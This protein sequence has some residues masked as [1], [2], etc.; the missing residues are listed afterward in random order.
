MHRFTD[1]T[2]RFVETLPLAYREKYH[3][4]TIEAHARLALRRE[5]PVEVGVFERQGDLTGVCIVADDRAGL[6]ALISE[7]LVLCDIDVVNAEAFT[8]QV[9]SSQLPAGQVLG[10]QPPGGAANN[11]L[12]AKDDTRPSSSRLPIAHLEGR[13]RYE[14]VDLFWLRKLERERSQ[15]LESQDLERLRTTLES[16]LDRTL[17]AGTAMPA[18]GQVTKS[19]SRVRFIDDEEGS[20]S[21][22]EIET[23]DRSGLLLSVSRA[24]FGQNV[25]VVRCEVRT[26]A[27]RRV[28]DRFKIAERDGS[29]VSAG[30]RLEIQ[31]AV[32]G[33]IE[34]AKRLGNSTFPPPNG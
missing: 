11:E 34:P 10:G 3:P 21:T 26:D 30:R 19:E 23:E 1:P 18:A 24:L 14:A 9:P 33:A 20:L 22:L 28:V 16:L 29:P 6:L 25:Q 7:A 5:G 17:P 32:L 4:A 12:A 27:A 2:R 31:V 15:P 13:P 8:R